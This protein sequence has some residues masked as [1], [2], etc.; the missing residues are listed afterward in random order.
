MSKAIHAEKAPKA[1]GP[2]SQAIESGPFLFASGQIPVDPATGEIVSGGIEEQAKQVFRNLKAI[3]EEAGLAEGSV[4]KTTVF[5]KSLDDFAV[6]NKLYAE[7]FSAPFPA[8]SCIEVSAL[9]KGALIEMEA[10]AER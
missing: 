10:I 6:V 5:L 4:V 2:Y 8:R 1:I 3:L 7:I 9:P